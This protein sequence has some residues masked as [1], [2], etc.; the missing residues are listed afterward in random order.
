MRLFSKANT[1][2]ELLQTFLWPR[3]FDHANKY[4]LVN[5]KFSI[6]CGSVS[7]SSATHT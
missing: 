6:S 4:Q 5:G 2:L 3:S 7:G 1:D